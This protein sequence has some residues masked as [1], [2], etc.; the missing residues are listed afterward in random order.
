MEKRSKIP[1]PTVARLPIY[2]R[3]LI[4]LKEN[5]VAVASSEDMA[6]RAG[7]KASQFRKDLSY[8]GEFGI[9]GLGYPVSHLLD[10]ISSIMQLNKEH[11]VIIAGAGNLGSALLNYPGFQK[12]GFKITRVLDNNPQ[13]I[14]K[15][16]GDITIEDIQ[17][18]PKNLNSS[19][20]IIA[21]P[22]SAAQQVAQTLIQSGV[23]A[24]LNFSGKKISPSKD[25]VVRNVD[26]THEL[27]ILTYYLSV[28][29][30]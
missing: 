23:K 16:L 20:G 12:W 8:F 14:G 2:F 11:E 25:I 30:K 5:G 4:E 1:E 26:M 29:N 21:V 19:I 7:V 10:R 22:A 27:A 6:A 24:I 13:K 28:E 18:I 9:Q 17:D 15:K 3:C